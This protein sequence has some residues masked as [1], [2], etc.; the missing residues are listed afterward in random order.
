MEELET[1]EPKT[2][3]EVATSLRELA[4]QLDEGGTVTL[5]FGTQRVTLD[6]ADPI[7]FKL[8]TE[9]ERAETGTGT[10]RSVEIEMVWGQEPSTAEEGGANTEGSDQ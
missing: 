10:K 6:P 7:T 1:Q 2:R 5:E 8:E 9:S 3:A 4:D